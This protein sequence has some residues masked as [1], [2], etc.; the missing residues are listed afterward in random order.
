[1]GKPPSSLIADRVSAARGESPLSGPSLDTVLVA[2][3]DDPILRDFVTVS[4]KNRER[5]IVVLS[6]DPRA[7]QWCGVQV[8]P[9]DSSTPTALSAQRNR[10]FSGLVLFPGRQLTD[11]VRS[12][13]DSVARL[14]AELDIE[15]ICVVSSYRVYL[16]D[17][18]AAEVETE[19]VRRLG[20]SS[21]RLAIFR[22]G[23]VLSPRSLANAR[24][25]SWG[26]CYPLVP[27]NWSCC[28]VHGQELFAAIEAELGERRSQRLVKLALL[29]PNRPWRVVLKEHKKSTFAQD[30]LTALALLLT[31]LGVSGLI[32]LVFFVLAKCLRIDERW[33]LTNLCPGSRRELLSLYNKYNFRY[34]KIVGYN[35]GVVHFGHKYPNKTLVSTIACNHRACVHQTSA[36]FDAGVI[37][38]QAIDVLRRSGKEFFVLPNY[39]YISVGTPF[40]VPIHGSAS[41]YSTLGETIESVML[42]D[43]IDDLLIRARWGDE[44]FARFMYDLERPLLLL[45]V[46]YRVK[47][48]ARYFRQH[49][50]LDDADSDT[51]L[52]CFTDRQACNVEIRKRRAACKAVDVYRYYTS[53]ERANDVMEFPQDSLGQLWDRIEQKRLL[54]AAFHGL[55]RRFGYHVELFL[56]PL[57]FDVFWRTHI[58]LPIAKIQL[59]YIKRD[60]LANSPFRE[61]DC[62]SADL[63]MLRKHKDVFDQ[64]IKDNLREVRFNPGKH[65]M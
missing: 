27:R 1:M 19:V 18:Q 26:F 5:R 4:G 45:R 25:A 34:V 38:R 63:F 7:L 53:G 54:A 21:A 56:T 51:I 65:S 42:Y 46:R 3:I 49:A 61:H 39:S 10:Q 6:T 12:L 33:R 23:L 16:G 22:P 13:I 50:R 14:A 28:F 29:G 64:Y 8:Y 52:D 31:L 43:P 40:F 41:E 32:A 20:G 24:L 2:G 60:R 30:V 44:A 15:R 9:L 35:N 47:D 36:V 17:R 11:R 58:S 59:R 62:V 37:L 55:M 57:E 48:K